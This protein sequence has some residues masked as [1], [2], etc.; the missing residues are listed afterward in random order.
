MFDLLSF[1]LGVF[2]GFVL[3]LVLMGVLFFCLGRKG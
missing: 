2:I 3:G 1:G